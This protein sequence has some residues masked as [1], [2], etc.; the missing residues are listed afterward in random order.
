MKQNETLTLRVNNKIKRQLEN[1]AKNENIT[2][3][4]LV[5]KYIDQGLKVS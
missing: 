2:L 3:G 4:A 5:R 1:K